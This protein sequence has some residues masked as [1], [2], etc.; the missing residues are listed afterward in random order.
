MQKYVSPDFLDNKKATTFLYDS[1]DK[2]IPKKQ[3]KKFFGPDVSNVLLMHGFEYSTSCLKG[4]KDGPQ[5]ILDW[6]K[7]IEYFNSY[8]N[9]L[10]VLL[11]GGGIET[12]PPEVFDTSKGVKSNLA[13]MRKNVL[14]QLNRGR[15]PL[16][17]GGEHT[18][19]Y[20]NV[21]A[22]VEY[23]GAK[24]TLVI[25]D[26]HPDLYDD[27]KGNIWSHAC[28]VKRL[29]EEFGDKLE[30]YYFGL[31]EYGVEEKKILDSDK[32]I[33]VLY[34]KDL[35]VGDSKYLD[36]FNN[37][38]FKNALS[39]KNIWLSVDVDGFDPSIIAATGTPVV[40]GLPWYKTMEFFKEVFSKNLVIG[41]DVVEL[42]PLANNDSYSAKNAA[43][44]VYNLLAIKRK[45]AK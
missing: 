32:R 2:L 20:S 38:I 11:R 35:K 22:A 15:F 16:V 44:L 5:A 14:K 3:Y 41:A 25:V 37:T 23:L 6:S 30:V 39:H 8:T 4:T 42:S 21:S 40:G 18:I 9:E 19:T 1:K 12:L 27:L 34:A 28:F 26:A 29:L 7:Q 24:V 33:N 10:S 13:L 43:Q 45:Y 17:L 36:F 31:R